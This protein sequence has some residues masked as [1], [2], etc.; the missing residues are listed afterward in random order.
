MKYILPAVALLLMQ[1]PSFSQDR[2]LKPFPEG[3]QIYIYPKS[4]QSNEKVQADKFNCYQKAKEE[5]GFDPSAIPEGTT[6]KPE[7]GDIKPV[8]TPQSFNGEHETPDK[9]YLKEEA[10]KKWKDEELLHYDK[11]RQEYYKAYKACLESLGYTVN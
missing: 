2:Q 11:K 8:K 5:T 9:G 7:L 6:N 3:E 1:L 10:G 4:G